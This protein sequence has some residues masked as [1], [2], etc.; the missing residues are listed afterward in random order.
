MSSI[1]QP[2]PPDQTR[3]EDWDTRPSKAMSSTESVSDEV[4]ERDLHQRV[5]LMVRLTGGAL[6]ERTIVDF[7]CV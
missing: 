3:H 2:D 6:K 7:F 1:A 4:A 5:P